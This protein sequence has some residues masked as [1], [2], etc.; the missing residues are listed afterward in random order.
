MTPDP[1]MATASSANNPAD[2]QS[3]NRYAYALNDPVNRFDPKG[4]YAP[5]LVDGPGDG[6]GTIW[7][8]IGSYSFYSYLPEYPG[9]QT[10]FLPLFCVAE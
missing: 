2:P 8:G 4:L 6:T 9:W 1:Y 10:F 3:W 5:M 7:G